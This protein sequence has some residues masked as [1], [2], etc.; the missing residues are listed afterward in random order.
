MPR[1]HPTSRRLE[2]PAADR[3]AS[4]SRPDNPRSHLVTIR[5]RQMVALAPCRLGVLAGRASIGTVQ[6]RPVR[7]FRAVGALR[8]ASRV[9]RDGEA[10]RRGQLAGWPV[11]A[12]E[13]GAAGCRCAD[14]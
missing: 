14:A 4:S 7:E 1:A 12:P 11:V 6:P 3:V 13:F 10:T 9:F 8:E 5:W 2:R